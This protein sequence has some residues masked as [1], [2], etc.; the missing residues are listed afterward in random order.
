MNDDPW[1]QSNIIV[2]KQL[3]IKGVDLQGHSWKSYILL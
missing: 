3:I 2:D 1:Y